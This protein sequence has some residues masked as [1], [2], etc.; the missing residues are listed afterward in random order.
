MNVETKYFD[1][2]IHMSDNDGRFCNSVH[3]K[4]TDKPD[5]VTCNKCKKLLDPKKLAAKRSADAK[6]PIPDGPV[7]SRK[8][9]R[10]D[11]A[12]RQ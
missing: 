10:K 4:I 1:H 2:L 7:M 6:R 12:N 5:E 8:Q 9:R 3:G 11:N